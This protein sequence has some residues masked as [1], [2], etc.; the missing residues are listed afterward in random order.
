M[1]GTFTDIDSEE[2]RRKK[3]LLAGADRRDN[4]GVENNEKDGRGDCTVSK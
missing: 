3:K 4:C 2:Y 1:N